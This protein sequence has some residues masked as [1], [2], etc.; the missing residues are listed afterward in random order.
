MERT[1]EVA[2]MMRHNKPIEEEQL[3]KIRRWIEEMVGKKADHGIT[4]D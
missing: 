1:K 3:R 4:E 2:S